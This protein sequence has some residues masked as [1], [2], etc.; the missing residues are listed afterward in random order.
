MSDRWQRPRSAWR[1][2]QRFCAFA[3][4]LWPED[5]TLA[6]RRG[7]DKGAASKLRYRYQGWMA[8]LIAVE[9]GRKESRK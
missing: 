5:V 6:N 2:D 4:E 9:E 7:Y 8:A 1:N 3:Q